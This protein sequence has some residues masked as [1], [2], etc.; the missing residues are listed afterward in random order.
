MGKTVSHPRRST[1]SRR[2]SILPVLLVLAIVVGVAIWHATRP[3][4]TPPVAK[5]STGVAQTQPDGERF[6]IYG[7]L[8][9]TAQPLT[10]LKNKGYIVGYSETRQDPAWVAYRLFKVDH[11]PVIPRPSGFHV[12]KRTK[13]RVSSGDYT[14]A[15]YDRGHMAPNHGI[16]T[17]YGA[18][19]Q[20][21]TFLMSNVC[22]QRSNLNKRVWERLESL[23]ADDYANRFEELWVIVGPIFD[24]SIER[25]PSGVEVPDAF[26]MVLLDVDGGKPRML[27]F[28][29]PQ[30][31]AGDEPLEK[32][33]TSVDE[34]ERQTGLDLFSDLEDELEERLESARTSHLWN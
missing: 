29:V 12:D 8:P 2:K 24:A 16:A 30:D 19:A 32:F 9:R 18:E 22:P 17:R 25:L 15:G 20:T 4:P 27:A 10:M 11:P 7:G 31:V 33:L 21:E 23:L 6:Y 1:G 28:I 3:K 14:N 5:G 26:F 34:V 13:A